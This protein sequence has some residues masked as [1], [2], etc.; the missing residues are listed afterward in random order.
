MQFLCGMFFMHLCKQ[1]NKWKDV[2][3]TVLIIMYNVL[4]IDYNVQLT[5]G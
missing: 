2:F 5:H 4:L 1:S 3:N